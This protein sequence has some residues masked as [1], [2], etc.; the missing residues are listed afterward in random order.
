MSTIKIM[1]I[2]WVLL[3]EY[4][5]GFDVTEYDDDGIVILYDTEE[6]ASK[7]L[8]DYIN[9]VNEAYKQGNMEFPYENDIKVEKVYVDQEKG[10]LIDFK[11]DSTYAMHD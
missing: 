4:I 9:D 6:E 5:Y 8:D 11:L 3:R 2:K 7:E 1:P 10:V